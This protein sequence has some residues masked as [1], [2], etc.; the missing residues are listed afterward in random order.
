[1][2]RRSILLLVIAAAVAPLAHLHSQSA[3]APAT[4]QAQPGAPASAPAKVTVIT[5]NLVPH[6]KS[7]LDELQAIKAANQKALDQQTKTL[8]ALDE[9]QKAAE[10]LRIF[11]K[12]S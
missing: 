3:P 4:A 6:L 2:K 11:G 5:I 10:E 8:Q 12:R 1:M 7:P 9:L